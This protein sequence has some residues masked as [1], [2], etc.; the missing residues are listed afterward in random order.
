MSIKKNNEDQQADI[1]RHKKG[2]RKKMEIEN[3]Y[4]QLKHI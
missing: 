3:I 4:G 1:K 2:K